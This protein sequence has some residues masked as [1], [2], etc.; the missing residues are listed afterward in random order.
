MT[1]R[2]W[3]AVREDVK[4]AIQVYEH[5]ELSDEATVILFQYLVDSGL[6]WELG[7]PY[8]RTAQQMIWDR[9]IRPVRTRRLSRRRT[10]R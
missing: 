3:A 7:Y 10:S 6:A 4:A 5:G 1:R 2:E 8:D 9:R